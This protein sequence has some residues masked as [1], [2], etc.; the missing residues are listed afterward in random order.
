VLA[1]PII[2][3]VGGRVAPSKFVTGGGH[4]AAGKSY[5]AAIIDDDTPTPAHARFAWSRFPRFHRGRRRALGRND[6][7]ALCSARLDGTLTQIGWFFTKAAL[8][9]SAA[10]TPYWP[11]VYQGGVE[12]YG[13]LTPTQMID[14]LAL[15]ET[16][17]GR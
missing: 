2:G 5:G 14:G 12:T 9:T 8:L 6:G 3:A 15:G 10:P 13:W 11:Y 7:L 1:G 4:G 17:P 16:T